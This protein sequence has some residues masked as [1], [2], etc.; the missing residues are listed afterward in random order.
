M[1][2]ENWVDHF[3][4]DRHRRWP[5]TAAPWP[6]ATAKLAGVF[7]CGMRIDTERYADYSLVFN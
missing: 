2:P 1:N 6:R 4:I 7:N 3:F 5:P